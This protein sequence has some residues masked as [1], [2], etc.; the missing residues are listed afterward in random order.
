[1]NQTLHHYDFWFWMRLT[2]PR[3]VVLRKFVLVDVRL[4]M[5]LTSNLAPS[6]SA[7]AISGDDMDGMRMDDESASSDGACIC[8]DL[9]SWCP[10]L[11]A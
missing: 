7:S 11:P 8:T 6:S 9:I 4:A 2:I 10:P 5:K 1:M 3:A